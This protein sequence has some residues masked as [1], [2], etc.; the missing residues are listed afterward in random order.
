MAWPLGG[1]QAV[2]IP[3]RL[4]AASRRIEGG[5][6]CKQGQNWSGCPS[7]RVGAPATSTCRENNVEA[8]F[9]TD[10]L[11]EMTSDVAMAALLML[12]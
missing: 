12:T 4:L 2:L 8:A 5:F 3:R 6:S 7:N 10:L 11:L 9:T 1:K